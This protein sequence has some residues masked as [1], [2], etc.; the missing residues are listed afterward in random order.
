MIQE[1]SSS[2]LPLHGRAPKRNEKLTCI[3]N[4]LGLRYKNSKPCRRGFCTQVFNTSE[5][6]KVKFEILILL[7][8][9]TYLSRSSG[10]A[11]FQTKRMLWAMMIPS[12]T[13]SREFKIH[14]S[15]QLK[16]WRLKSW[17]LG[18]WAEAVHGFLSLIL[19]VLA[20]SPF[21]SSTD[22]DHVHPEV[23]KSGLKVNFWS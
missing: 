12:L 23:V 7:W 21:A 14:W 19:A 9:F 16:S 3:F 2:F 13:I 10:S 18:S 17:T 20:D 1:C 15:W 4:S 22:T 11:D 8:G 6:V 5:S